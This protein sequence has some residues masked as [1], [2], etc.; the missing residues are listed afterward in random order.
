[1]GP[2]LPLKKAAE[3]LKEQ[4]EKL[5][6]AIGRVAGDDYTLCLGA[7]GYQDF[8]KMKESFAPRLAE[9]H[10]R[11]LDRLQTLPLDDLASRRA[12]W[13]EYRATYLQY[14]GET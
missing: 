3:E 10:A 6:A 8:S 1:M 13:E 7:Y 12:M 2:W 9:L 4:E 5:S 11:W 14:I